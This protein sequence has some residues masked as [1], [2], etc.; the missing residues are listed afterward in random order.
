MSSRIREGF[1][2]EVIVKLKPEQQQGIFQGTRRMEGIS[3]TG[4]NKD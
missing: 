2:E 1:L 3:F 4:K